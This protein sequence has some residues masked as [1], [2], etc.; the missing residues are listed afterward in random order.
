VRAK[1]RIC[2][3]LLAA[4]SAA[5]TTCATVPVAE[6]EP[7]PET[8]ISTEPLFRFVRFDDGSYGRDPERPVSYNMFSDEPVAIP[9]SFAPV[10]REFRGVWVAT[11]NNL[12]VP[13]AASPEEFRLEFDKILDVLE[14]WGM[15]A[16]IFQVRPMLDAFYPS[17]ANPW[18]Q[19][20]S[21][22]QGADPGWD[23]LEWM[24]GRT[25]ERG[26]EFHAWFNPYRIT[27]SDHR[28]LSLPG[29]SAS[30]TA[31][32]PVPEILG[33]LNRAGIL[34]GEN[35]AVR[36]P[37]YVYAF[38]GRLYLDAGFPAVRGHVVETVTEVVRNY[39]IDAVHFDDYF[40]PY[41][42]GPLSFGDAGEDGETFARHGLGTFPN[43]RAGIE[44]WRRENNT[45]LV[46][47]VGAAISAE[48]AKSGRAVQFGISP[49]GIWE[50]AANNP[51]GS[52]TPTGSSRTFAGQVFADT[53]LWLSEGLVDYAIPQI[54]WSFDQ[55]AA[56]YAELVRWWAAVADGAEANLYVGHANYKHL[57]NADS[58]AAWM[59]PEEIL[60]QL[61]YNRLHPQVS[62]SAFFRLGSLLPGEGNE[63]RMLAA[64]GA[65]ELLRAHFRSHVALVPPKPWLSPGAPPPPGN[66]ARRG[67]SITWEDS[68][69]GRARYFAVYRVARARMSGG[70]L[71]GLLEDPRNIVA[72]IPGGKGR[73]VFD[74]P[75]GL[76]S[77]LRYAYVVTAFDA[78]HVESAPG[79]ARGR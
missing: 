35:F 17:R 53:R 41:R 40:Y 67:N 75:G 36:N 9:V 28:R 7:E 18:S 58:E 31:E 38:N 47:R 27:A 56:P 59:N 30:A 70:G 42:V 49:F 15:N 29:V 21:G 69:D 78:A 5:F 33:A 14:D 39:D 65:I 12:D 23:P 11:I 55:R 6:P 20:L 16:I 3:A 66:V 63:P 79:I 34:S 52:G 71:A 73:R 50:H 48:N 22:R 26:I 19:F 25:H 13:V 10:K 2:V 44:A 46:R 64:N 76:E 77:R 68:G 8:V 24:V 51:A 32:T 1:A 54:Y 45:D 57:E 74:V 61:R 72:K 37:G 60:D 62:G 4:A 43:T